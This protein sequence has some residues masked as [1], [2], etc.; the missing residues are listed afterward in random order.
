MA[1]VGCGN[2]SIAIDVLVARQRRRRADRGAEPRDVGF[3]PSLI[4][5]TSRELSSAMSDGVK[6]QVAARER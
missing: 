2:S 3:E 4:P 1:E 6:L 5:I